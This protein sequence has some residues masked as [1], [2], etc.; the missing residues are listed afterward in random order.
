MTVIR[1]AE[2]R[3]V[4]WLLAE[5]QN[6]AEFFGT[7]MSLFPKDE[8]KARAFVS[9]LI[10]DHVV[11]L[12]EDRGGIRIGFIGGT[13]SGHPYN[14]DVRTLT[15]LFWWVA[16]PRRG[17]SAGAKLLDTWVGFGRLNADLV[18]V[19]SLA[20]S[21]ID[22]RVLLKRGFHE[23]ERTYMLDMSRIVEREPATAVAG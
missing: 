15:E 3:D 19:S 21:P 11:F 5:L 23:H 14:E 17:T 7:G 1:R 9:W 22:D 8:E 2:V 18:L 12:A 16:E 20:Q 6:F 4:G 10:A 13:L